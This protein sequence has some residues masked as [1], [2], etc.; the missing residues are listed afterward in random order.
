MNA[1]VIEAASEC[2][3]DKSLLKWLVLN[4][5]VYLMMMSLIYVMLLVVDIIFITSVFRSHC[6]TGTT[7]IIEKLNEFARM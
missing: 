3:I 6:L 4:D 1:N 2:F 5:N 7:E